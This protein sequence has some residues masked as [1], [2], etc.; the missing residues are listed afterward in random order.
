MQWLAPWNE[1]VDGA[2]FALELAREMPPQHVLRG[3]PVNAIARRFDC[4]DV[5]F[6]LLD[7]SARV[8][9]VHLTYNRETKAQWP[10]T[11]IFKDRE[12]FVRTRMATDHEGFGA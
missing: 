12:E 7:G 3:V 6:E 8:A 4:D 2:E 9:V 10:H 11:E 1:V 5:L